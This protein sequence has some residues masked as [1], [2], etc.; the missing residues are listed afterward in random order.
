VPV[1][2]LFRY[3]FFTYSSIRFEFCVAKNLSNALF[4]VPAKAD[5]SVLSFGVRNN[6]KGMLIVL[7]KVHTYAHI[8]HTYIII[9]KINKATLLEQQRKKATLMQKQ[10]F[11]QQLLNCEIEYI[12][13]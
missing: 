8:Y 2:Q 3:L 7:M 13:D 9:M 6:L 1:L 5:V 10:Q 4:S 12:Y 11:R